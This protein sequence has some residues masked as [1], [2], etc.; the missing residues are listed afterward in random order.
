MPHTYDGMTIN[1][2]RSRKPLQPTVSK[3]NTPRTVL[4]QKVTSFKKE[5]KKH[6]EER[7][8]PNF[9]ISV[10][11]Y[12]TASLFVLFCFFQQKVCL[13]YDEKVDTLF[14]HEAEMAN[15]LRHKNMLSIYGVVTGSSYSPTF[16]L[17]SLTTKSFYFQSLTCRNL[18]EQRRLKLV[19]SFLLGPFCLV[20]N[21]KRTQ[22]VS[23]DFFTN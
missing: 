14:L 6:K 13:R 20:S 10:V 3:R 19:K 18:A 23:K 4:T 7:K 2:V 12:L 8:L 16:A 21:E 9:A 1:K 15:V 11:S 17:V 22:N 5:K